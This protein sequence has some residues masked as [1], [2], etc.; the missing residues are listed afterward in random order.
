MKF[1]LNE[2]FMAVGKKKN[3]P[4]PLVP[5]GVA[6][7]YEREE[8]DNNPDGVLP[9]PGEGTDP[10]EYNDGSPRS[11]TKKLCFHSLVAEGESPNKFGG[12]NTVTA[13]GVASSRGEGHNQEYN[14]SKGLSGRWNKNRDWGKGSNRTGE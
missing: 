13:N 5:M 2:G 9:L 11:G 8:M 1:K 3:F 6:E 10:S 7:S 4:A 12:V 14:W